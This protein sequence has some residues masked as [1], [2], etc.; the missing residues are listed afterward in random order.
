VLAGL[1]IGLL[2]LHSCRCWCREA[3]PLRPL[4][5]K[6]TINT[7]QMAI[8]NRQ[9][10][11]VIAWMGRGENRKRLRTEQ[12]NFARNPT[13]QNCSFLSLH[14]TS[15]HPSTATQYQTTEAV[16]L[17]FVTLAYFVEM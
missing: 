7:A 13:Q 8:K 15:Y 6:N 2:V 1:Q 17:N 4:S 12:L 16:V 11:I 10:S 3:Y 9:K 5:N 14:E